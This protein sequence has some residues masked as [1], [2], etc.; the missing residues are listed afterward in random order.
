MECEA[1]PKRETNMKIVT[2][3]GPFH[4]D[5]V[6]AVAAIRMVYPEATVERTR[7]PKRIAD[8]TVVVD[9]GDVYDPA[10][11]RFDHHQKVNKPQPRANGVPYS[12]FGLVWKALGGEVIASVAPPSDGVF[13][14]IDRK[15]VQPIDALDNGFG[16]RFIAGGLEHC[17]VSDVISALNPTWKQD[18]SPA[19]FDKAFENAVALATAILK[20][21]IDSSV[22]KWD[23]RNMVVGTTSEVVEIGVYAPVMDDLIDANA[24]AKYLIFPSPGGEWMVQCVPPVAGS[25][26]QRKPLPEAWKGMRNE[27]LQELTGVKD[28]IFCH[29]FRF[30]CG[31]ATVEGARALAA[32]ALK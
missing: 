31:A 24:N 4:A 23:A 30:I 6:F 29:D 18:T 19:A 15:L 12:S 16:T 2:H 14:E 21:E 27:A 7:D 11:F 32:L 5:D 17:T 9:V 25:F 13:N 22:A 10:S 20:R 26:D 3:N 1:F 8:A 28:A